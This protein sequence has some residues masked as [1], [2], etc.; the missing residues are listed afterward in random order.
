[1]RSLASKQR[2]ARNARAGGSA[3]PG[4]EVSGQGR[5][6]SQILQLQRSI[7]NHAVGRLLQ[8]HGQGLEDESGND[9]LAGL[10]R[11]AAIG[12]QIIQRMA[13]DQSRGQSSPAIDPRCEQRM[14]DYID[15]NWLKALEVQFKN[16]TCDDYDAFK[17]SVMSKLGEREY[18]EFTSGEDVYSCCVKYVVAI[19]SCSPVEA[20][21]NSIRN[22]GKKPPHYDREV[23]EDNSAHPF[24]LMRTISLSDG[25]QFDLAYVLAQIPPEECHEAPL[26]HR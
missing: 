3:R 25:N 1:L 12:N 2:A 22:F 15:Q 19:S 4:R 16:K 17:S 7:G 9:A 8:A 11:G 18:Q 21:P 20:E 6:V 10:N 5:E 14:K 24:S 13:S 26:A 23:I